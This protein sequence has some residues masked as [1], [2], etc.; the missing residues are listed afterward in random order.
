MKKRNLVG[1]AF[2]RWSVIA[3]AATRKTPCGSS[4]AYWLC[5]CDCGTEGEVRAEHLMSGR[6]LSCGCHKSDAA[7]AQSLKH[8]GRHTALYDVWTQ[9]LQRCE[10][11]KNKRY[12]RYGGRGI[13]V[14]MEWHDFGVFQQWAMSNGYATGLTIDRIDNDGAYEANNCRWVT[15]LENCRNSSKVE[16]VEWQGA[17]VPLNALAEQY[18]LKKQTVY[19]RLK[20]N[21]WTLRQSL[22]LDPAPKKFRAHKRQQAELERAEAKAL[23]QHAAMDD[24]GDY[25][26]RLDAAEQGARL[27]AGRLQARMGGG[28]HG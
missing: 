3:Q 26:E 13:V 8:G 16:M 1:L 2:G 18:G 10:N 9:M 27:A 22:G 6:T 20:L 23:E 12:S 15:N 17:Q 11:P 28:R 14:C 21:G 5:R 19:R 7:F 4:K 25:F 24:M